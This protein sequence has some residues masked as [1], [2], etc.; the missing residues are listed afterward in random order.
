LTEEIITGLSRNRQ[1]FVISHNS[2]F[3]YKNKPVIVQQVSEELG[4]RYVLEGSVRRQ[5]NRVRITVQL[6][7]AVEG[8]HIW[9]N[10]YDR[11]MEDIL[12][13]QSEL[14]WQIFRELQIK[15]TDGEMARDYYWAEKV[16]G[17]YY[18]TN[19][20]GLQYLS[21][22]EW[23]KA[24]QLADKLIEM[25]PN[26]PFGYYAKGY[27]LTYIE[28][29]PKGTSLHQKWEIRRMRVQSVVLLLYV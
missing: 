7:D 6:I 10:I 29:M 17:D 15:L 22:R 28:D 19:L 4:V 25:D 24:I 27:T 12:V 18:E 23:E 8:D 1:L 21:Q 5:G 3:I 20:I 9:S 16:N 14:M 26:D 11:E 2:S 13:L